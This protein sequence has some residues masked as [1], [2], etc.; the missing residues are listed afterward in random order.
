MSDVPL[1]D[2][3]DVANIPPYHAVIHTDDERITVSMS[4]AHHLHALLSTSYNGISNI[5]S[6]K[7]DHVKDMNK[8]NLPC[9]GL[10]VPPSLD[11]LLTCRTPTLI[12]A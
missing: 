5:G 4:L 6:N 9:M 7:I 12:C 2:T 3:S 8:P 1:P 11:A 10:A